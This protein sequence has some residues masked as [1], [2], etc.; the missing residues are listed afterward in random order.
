MNQAMISQLVPVLLLALLLLIVGGAA[1]M[2]ISRKGGKTS[3]GAPYASPPLPDLDTL[4]PDMD[5]HAPAVTLADGVTVPATGVMR[6]LRDSASGALIAEID[7]L[8]Y[9]CPPKAAH[10]EFMRRYQ[11]VV[12]ELLAG[13]D[14][15]PAAPV[16]SGPPPGLVE[17][18]PARPPAPPAA[19][20]LSA[21]EPL[22][23]D[24]PKFIMT[25]SKEA[26]RLG[27][28]PTVSSVPEINIGESIEAYLQYRLGTHDALAQRSIHVL[29]AGADGVRIE[30]DGH[31]YDGIDM[32]SDPAVQDFLR[33][34][35]TEWQQRQ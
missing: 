29:P 33:Q 22:P 9:V 15:A 19:A 27:R 24:L 6:L 8:A 34:T 35:I 10:P 21:A 25:E 13:P 1:V 2:L 12:R 20:P 11:A 14:E 4:A 18:P 28:K 5:A 17:T 26:P 7:G 3:P 16:Q 30:V 32:V 31:S 23:G